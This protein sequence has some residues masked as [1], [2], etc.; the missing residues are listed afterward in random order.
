ME[1]HGRTSFAVEHHGLP[2]ASVDFHGIPRFSMVMENRGRF[3]RFFMENSTA[4]AVAFSMGFIVKFHGGPLYPT[5]FPRKMMVLHDIPQSFMEYL[6][7]LGRVFVWFW[8]KRT[9]KKT[10][11]PSLQSRKRTAQEKGEWRWTSHCSQG[12]CRPKLNR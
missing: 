7:G 3:P 8:T 9:Q 1:F 10:T 11:Y 2:W 12:R 4:I 6:N 5:D